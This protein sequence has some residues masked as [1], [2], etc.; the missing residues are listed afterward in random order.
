MKKYTPRFMV[1]QKVDK[2]PHRLG[3][4]GEQFLPKT[5]GEER[6][7]GKSWVSD[8][9]GPSESGGHAPLKKVVPQ[10]KKIGSSKGKAVKKDSAGGDL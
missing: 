7:S 9:P 6:P 4:K 3:H 1:Q 10:K 8:L 2:L 5:F